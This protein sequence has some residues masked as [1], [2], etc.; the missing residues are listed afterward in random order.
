MGVQSTYHGST[1]GDHGDANAQ[2]SVL[3]C[4]GASIPVPRQVREQME[5]PVWR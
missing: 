4:R 5:A 2:A 3:A 1:W